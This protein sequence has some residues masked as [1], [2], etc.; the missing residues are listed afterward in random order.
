MTG[1]AYRAALN[2]PF[3]RSQQSISSVLSIEDSPKKQFFFLELSRLRHISSMSS[4]FHSKLNQ[5]A[6]G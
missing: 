4:S 6:S 2:P 3:V 5:H 1:I